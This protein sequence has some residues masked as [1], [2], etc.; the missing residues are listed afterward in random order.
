MAIIGV[1]HVPVGVRDMERSLTFYPD[2]LGLRVRYCAVEHLPNLNEVAAVSRSAVFLEY[3]DSQAHPASSFLVLDERAKSELARRR[4]HD[5][6]SLYTPGASSV[7]TARWPSPVCRSDHGCPIYWLM[8]AS[9]PGPGKI[10]CWQYRYSRL[11]TPNHAGQHPRWH[12]GRFTRRRR[13]GAADAGLFGDA[14]RGAHNH[15]LS[16]ETRPGRHLAGY[17]AV[18]ITARGQGGGRAADLA[19]GRGVGDLVGQQHH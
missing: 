1:S 6:G 10:G 14:A 2:V 12:S 4:G 11:T 17:S 16:R 9:M 7:I 3:T 15:P 19:R 8:S 5:G 18:E 13:H